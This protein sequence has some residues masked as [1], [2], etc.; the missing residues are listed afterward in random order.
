MPWLYFALSVACFAIA[1]RTHSLG[2][3]AVFLLL[4]L[5][6]LLAGALGLVAA[7]IQ[8]RTQSAAALLGPEQAAVIRRRAAA[9]AGA[10]PPRRE[11]VLGDE[12]ADA[13]AEPP[14]VALDRGPAAGEASPEDDLRRG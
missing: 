13:D 14:G 7:R 4:A 8:Q 2:I 3:A 10:T 9:A 5:G 12:P 6:L 11:P 1:F